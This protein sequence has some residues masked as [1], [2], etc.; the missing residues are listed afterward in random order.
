M[1]GTIRDPLEPLAVEEAGDDFDALCR[2]PIET[3]PSV[4]MQTSSA[5][6][7]GR[8]YGLDLD[9]QPIV[10]GL[11]ELPGEL[12]CARTTISLTTQQVGSEVVV[13]LEGGDVRRPIIV[14]V[15][16]QRSQTNPTD[17]PLRGASIHS[18]D[19]RYTITAEREIVLRCGDSSITLTRA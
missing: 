19:E 16:Q 10:V 15:L 13:L 18:D 14:G 5:A 1:M 6:A 2:R 17:S 3:V 4:G 11:V 7:I 12:L 8:L 9:G